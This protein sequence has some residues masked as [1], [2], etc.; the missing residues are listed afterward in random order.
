MNP[1]DVT[2]QPD[3]KT[4]H[5]GRRLPGL[6]VATTTLLLAGLLV[7]LWWRGS[8]PSAPNLARTATAR[9]RNY[10]RS[11][12]PD[13]AFQAVSEVRDESPEAGEAMAVAGLALARMGQYRTARM[14]LERALKLQPDQF[15]AAVTLGELNLDLGN[16]QRG[17]EM[18]ERAARLRPREFGVWRLLGHAFNDNNEPA[19][20][21]RAYQKALEL[22][23]NDREVLTALIALLINSGQSARARS[24]IDR[25]I[26][27]NPDDPVVLGLAARGAFEANQIDEALAFADRALKRDPQDPD[28]LLARAQCRV[29]RAQWQAALPDAERAAAL[30]P[31]DLPPLQLLGIIEARLGLTERAARTTARRVQ[32]QHRAKLM[33]QLTADLEAHPDDPKIPWKM[34]ETACEAGSFRLASRCFEA[35]LALDPNYQPARASLAALTAAHPELA[36]SRFPPT[37]RHR[38]DRFPGAPSRSAR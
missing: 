30:A 15:E 23:P 27:S 11:G 19:S 26:A 4:T 22:R 34:G 2:T 24:W 25:A 8:H 18:L 10:L 37:P 5:P 36:R 31:N 21:E 35:S 13:L 3:G 1:T 20:A 14:A 32:V 17:A 12:R 28:A 33:D 7:G 9:G 6:L 16:G 29:A 38:A